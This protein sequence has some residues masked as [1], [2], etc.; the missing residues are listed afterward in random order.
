[1]RWSFLGGVLEGKGARALQV[2]ALCPLIRC[3]I[4]DYEDAKNI[5]VDALAG[6]SPVF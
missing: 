5:P 1:M 3:Q 4:A 2:V 6:L